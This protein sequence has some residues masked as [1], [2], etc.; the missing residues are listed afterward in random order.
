[1]AKTGLAAGFIVSALCPLLA[2]GVEIHEIGVNKRDGQYL[3]AAT[4]TLQAPLE[5]VY[6]I[7]SDYE[8]FHRLT[9]GIADT[10]VLENADEMISYTLIDS[11]VL[12]FC[13]KFERVERVYLRPPH[14]IH[15]SVIPERSDFEVYESTWS[16]SERDG[17]TSITFTATMDPAFWI[18]PLIDTWAIRR[19]LAY[20]AEQVGGRV[21]FLFA[22]GYELSD[23][24]DRRTDRQR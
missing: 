21:E 9:G 3:I 22:N 1:M 7:L 20:T 11:C 24:P 10:R 15:T 6:E 14:E 12:F 13:R 23:L 5:F 4:S 8:N 2:S 18:P 16:L 19:K 17:S